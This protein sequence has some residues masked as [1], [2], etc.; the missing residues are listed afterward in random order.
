MTRRFNQPPSA[1][2]ALT[3]AAHAVSSRENQFCKFSCRLFH[4]STLNFSCQLFPAHVNWVLPATEGRVQS[5]AAASAATTDS[6]SM[7]CF[8]RFLQPTVDIALSTGKELLVSGHLAEEYGH[9]L[10]QRKSD[11]LRLQ[12]I[13]WDAKWNRKWTFGQVCQCNKVPV[14]QNNDLV[15]GSVLGTGG[16]SLS[17]ICDE[18]CRVQLPL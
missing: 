2:Y 17:Q 18:M 5:A 14:M 6:Q 12:C 15:L 7:F 1:F 8:H 4:F 11:N 13:W 16:V 10:Q 9:M 3:P